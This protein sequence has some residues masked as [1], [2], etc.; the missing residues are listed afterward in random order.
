MFM[1]ICATHQKLESIPRVC[2]E[3]RGVGGNPQ[4]LLG[5]AKGR[6]F[7]K[8]ALGFEIMPPSVFGASNAVRFCSGAYQL[9]RHGGR[10]RCAGRTFGGGGR[11]RRRCAFEGPE[12]H[13][14]FFG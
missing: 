3:G 8:N 13:Q 9:I 7:L 2:S 6:K 14:N 5:P 10:R 4:T 11:R 1:W 12:Q